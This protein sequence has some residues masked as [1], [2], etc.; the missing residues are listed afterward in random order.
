[1][2]SE[3][4]GSDVGVKTGSEVKAGTASDAKTDARSG[5]WGRGGSE[6]GLSSAKMRLGF[7]VAASQ[8]KI[9]LGI[10]WGSG[11]VSGT[12][13]HMSLGGSG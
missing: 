12:W 9:I 1:M 11:F 2:D 5:D 10:F 7:L 8:G 3:G 6:G 13:Y 4:A